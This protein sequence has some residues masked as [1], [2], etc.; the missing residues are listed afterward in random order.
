MPEPLLS[1][2]AKTE[3]PTQATHFISYHFIDCTTVN[4]HVKLV[5]VSVPHP[6]STCG[7][8]GYDTM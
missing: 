8:L 3:L 4:L 6:H 5:H 2:V 1:M 7:P